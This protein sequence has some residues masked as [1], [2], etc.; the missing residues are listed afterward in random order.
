MWGVTSTWTCKVEFCQ[1]QEPRAASGTAAERMEVLN[2][3]NYMMY[4]VESRQEQRYLSCLISGYSILS[5]LRSI[6]PLEQP[7]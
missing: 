2:M 5:D 3:H 6:R 7:Q 1:E 4:E